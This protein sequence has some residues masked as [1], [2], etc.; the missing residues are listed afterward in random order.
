MPGSLRPTTHAL[1][2]RYAE[3]LDDRGVGVNEVMRGSRPEQA[4]LPL[5]LGLGRSGARRGRALGEDAAFE[6]PHFV[7]EESQEAEAE[8]PINVPAGG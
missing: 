6:R 7:V 5:G 1:A 4:R 8:E 2:V 3:R